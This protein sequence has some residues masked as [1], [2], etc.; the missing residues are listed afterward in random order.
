MSTPQPDQQLT[1]RRVTA[2]VLGILA[3]VAVLA[4]TWWI[5]DRGGPDDS[6]APVSSGPSV[7]AGDSL[8]PP[9]TPPSGSQSRPTRTPAT[10]VPERVADT[11]ALI[12]AGRWPE[13]A[14]AP[15]T[16]GG[17]TFRNNERRLPQRGADGSRMRYKEWDV[18]PKKRGRGRDAERIVTAADGS[19]WYTLDHYQTFTKIRGPSS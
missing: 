3:L 7:T 4:L 5:D 8:G 12:D 10:D 18:N 6:A 2:S 11:L 1:R 14:N 16:K 13:A 15:G 9:P 17:V 19:A